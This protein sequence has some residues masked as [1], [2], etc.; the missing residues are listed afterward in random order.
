MKN[1]L[2]LGCVF[3]VAV[4]AWTAAPAAETGLIATGWDSPTAARFRRELAEFEKRAAF[5]GTTIFPTRKTADGQTRHAHC[6]FSRERGEWSELADCVADLKAAQP[7]R[8]TQNFLFL[9]ANPGDVDWFDDAQLIR[10]E[11]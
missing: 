9:Y 10:M 7:K 3:S 1:R 2:W 11:D 6:A 4:F 5:D 8:A